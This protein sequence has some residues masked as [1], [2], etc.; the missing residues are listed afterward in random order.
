MGWKERGFVNIPIY[1][2]ES[3]G[4]VKHIMVEKP[5]QLSTDTTTI[6]F[7]TTMVRA[8]REEV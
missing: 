5:A 6:E 2:Y 4:S 8:I 1:T 7:T 3:L